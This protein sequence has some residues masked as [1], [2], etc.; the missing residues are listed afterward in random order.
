MGKRGRL[1]RRR[2]RAGHRRRGHRLWPPRSRSGRSAPCWR[3]SVP[4]TDGLPQ[5]GDASDPASLFLDHDVAGSGPSPRAFAREPAAR[6]SC[7]VAAG[8]LAGDEAVVGEAKRCL[9][10]SCLAVSPSDLA[11]ALIALDARVETNLRVLHA[12][13]L[14]AASLG[15]STTLECG[16][17]LL[18]V[19]IPL[20]DGNRGAA[21]KK[22]RPRK[23]IDSRSSTLPSL[24]GSPVAQ[25][26]APAF[27][28]EPS[29]LCRC[30]STLPSR[31]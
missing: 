6:S 14:F 4:S 10:C 25:S 28:P 26:S 13:E 27:A 9:N 18:A 17:I 1:R 24:C 15:A 12:D 30:A 21:F 3:R 19:R 23:S 29:R 31:L 11:P 7:G 2:I 20:A 8:A 22:F 5:N 16:E